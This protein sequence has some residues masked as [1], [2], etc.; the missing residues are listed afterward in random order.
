MRKGKGKGK[1][2]LQV[3]VEE[4]EPQDMLDDVYMMKLR[5]FLVFSM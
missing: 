2:K 4:K 3:A 5:L 1:E